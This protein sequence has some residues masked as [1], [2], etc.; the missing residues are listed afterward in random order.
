MGVDISHDASISQN[1]FPKKSFADV[2]LEKK[3]RQ[4]FGIST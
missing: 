1:N 4:I 3:V 2:E